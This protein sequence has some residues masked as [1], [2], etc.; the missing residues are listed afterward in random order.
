MVGI[1]RSKVIYLHWPS[2]STIHVGKYAIA[3]WILWV[4]YLKFQKTSFSIGNIYPT[5]PD[6]PDL[7]HRGS[8]MPSDTSRKQKVMVKYLIR[9]GNSSKLIQKFTTT[10]TSGIRLF[11]PWVRD[12]CHGLWHHSFLLGAQ[13]GFVK[14]VHVTNFCPLYKMDGLSVPKKSQWR[15]IPPQDHIQLYNLD[16]GDLYQTRICDARKKRPKSDSLFHRCDERSWPKFSQHSFR[17]C[18]E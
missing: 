3:P 9:N 4:R 17:I 12:S 11:Y 6:L 18:L 5:L 15:K 10:S 8:R 7:H 13:A 2:K 16:L 1:T 14:A